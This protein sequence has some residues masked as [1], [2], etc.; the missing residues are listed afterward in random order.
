M[1]LHSE[2]LNTLQNFQSINPSIV[3]NEGNVM[4]IFIEPLSKIV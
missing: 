1:K 4:L 3:I 2:T